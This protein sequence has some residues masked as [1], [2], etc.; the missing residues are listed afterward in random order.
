MNWTRGRVG[1]FI[2]TGQAL[3]L[4]LC[5]WGQ[6]VG[7]VELPLDVIRTTT[8]QSRAVLDDPA[9]QGDTQRKQRLKK[10][11]EVIL[12]HFDQQ[13]IAQ[14]SLGVH[15]RGLTQEQQGRFTDLF[16]QLNQT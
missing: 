1:R 2:L 6:S 5:L 9:Y 11:W 16:L 13:A 15:W 10:M 7:A 3:V 4:L 12:P 8:Q 14:R